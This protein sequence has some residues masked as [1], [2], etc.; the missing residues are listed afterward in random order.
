[1]TSRLP[2]QAE[3]AIIKLFEINYYGWLVGGSNQQ[4]QPIAN[5]A[6][7]PIKSAGLRQGFVD[8]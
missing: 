3:A 4:P 1:M 6:A 5:G 7:V 8:S 2:W